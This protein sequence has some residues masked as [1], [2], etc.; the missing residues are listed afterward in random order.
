MTKIPDPT[1]P[2]LAQ[3][4]L[5]RPDLLQAYRDRRVTAAQLAAQF[6]HATSY[7]LSTLSRLGVKRHREGPSTYEIQKKN[8][9]LAATRRE[10]RSFLAKKVEKRE[11]SLEKA[12]EIAGCSERTMRRYLERH[13]DDE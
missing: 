13:K 6:G 10:F 7:L 5:A 9:L 4:L 1:A 11:I 8:S 12:A 2:N 3:Q